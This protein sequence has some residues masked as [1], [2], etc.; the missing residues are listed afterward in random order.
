M[1]KKKED[2]PVNRD[3]RNLVIDAWP[4]FLLKPMVKLMPVTELAEGRRRTWSSMNISSC[5]TSIQP[6]T[7][8]NKQDRS[9]QQDQQKASHQM[10]TT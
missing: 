6:T 4:V 5:K 8:L 2:R 7:T 9:T 1:K 3:R 10:S